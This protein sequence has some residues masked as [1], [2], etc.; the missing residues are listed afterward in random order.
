MMIGPTAC[1][2]LLL[3]GHSDVADLLD[4]SQA[5]DVS[6]SVARPLDERGR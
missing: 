3:S 5:G 4:E 6:A 2:G 1:A